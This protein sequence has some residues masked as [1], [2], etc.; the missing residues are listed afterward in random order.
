MIRQRNRLGHLCEQSLSVRKEDNP[1]SLVVE[2]S[3]RRVQPAAAPKV[4]TVREVCRAEALFERG[5]EEL[6]VL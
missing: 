1:G 3:E 6:Y 2:S 4:V 5:A